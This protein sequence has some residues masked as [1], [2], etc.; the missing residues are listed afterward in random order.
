DVDLRLDALI[1]ADLLPAPAERARWPAALA[2]AYIIEGM[3]LK[4]NEWT[5]AMIRQTERAEIA[6]GEAIGADPE[7]AWGRRSPYGPIEQIPSGD[8]RADMVERKGAPPI[9]ATHLPKLVVR[10]DGNLG[11]SPA[12]RFAHYQGSHWSS[13][14]CD[15]ARLRQALPKP[16]RVERRR[17]NEA[18]QLYT[19]AE[20]ADGDRPIIARSPVPFIKHKPRVESVPPP[21]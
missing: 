6:L 21:P 11:I 4:S 1:A 16:L 5:A 18:E 13:I 19:E 15:L 14:E 10:I 7:L 2:L 17:L 8:F 20:S 12:H 9:S 3:P